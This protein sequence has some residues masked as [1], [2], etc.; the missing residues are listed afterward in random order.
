MEEW[1]SHEVGTDT[2][3]YMSRLQLNNNNKLFIINKLRSEL[4]IHTVKQHH[5]QYN[6]FMHI[7]ILTGQH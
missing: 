7:T 6:I 2:L 1:R 4:L 3:H 5:E